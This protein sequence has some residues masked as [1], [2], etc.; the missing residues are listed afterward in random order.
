MIGWLRR[1]FGRSSRSMTAAM[2]VLDEVWQPGRVRARERLEARH[3]RV[4]PA[5][6]PGDRLLSERRLRLRRRVG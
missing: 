3:E 4:Q 2:S 5:P 6:S 1:R